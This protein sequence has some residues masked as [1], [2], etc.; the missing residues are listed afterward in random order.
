[1]NKEIKILWIDDE[2]D[3]LKPH[4][5]FLEEK[6]YKVFTAY[7]ADD[8]FEMVRDAF[9]HIILLDEHMPGING[10]EALSRL[11]EA[12]PSSPVIMITKS[13][14]EN[15]MEEA[16]GANIDDYLIKPVN[17]KQILLS[18]KKNI[19]TDK[20]VSE[21][22]I[23]NYQ[24]EFQELSGLINEAS[25]PEDW[26]DIYRKIVYWELTLEGKS[27]NGMQEVLRTQKGEANNAFSK[28]ISRYYTSWFTDNSNKPLISP[29]IFKEKVFPSIDD[30]T[31]VFFL[32]IDNLRYDHWQVLKPLITELFAVEEEELYYSIL[33]TATQYSRNS[34]FAG[35]MPL[36][37]SYIYPDIW[38]D[39]EEEGGKNLKEQSLLQHQIAR[40]GYD[41]EFSYD[42]IS[43][44]RTGKKVL[45][46]LSNLLEY[47]LSILIFNYI[48]MLS[49]SRTEMDVIKE[50]ANDES[51]YR[52]LTLSW[53]KHSPL[54]TLLKELAGK[55]V[56]I[57]LTT[58][59][60]NI[61][62]KNPV[63]VQGDKKTT[64]NLRYK[65][66]KNLSYKKNK[67]FGVSTPREIHLPKPH[68]NT[69]YIFA[70][71]QD[72]LI[73]PNNYN[74]F[75]NYYKNTF[76]HG[77]ISMEEMLIPIVTLTPKSLT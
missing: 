24:S 66:G 3:L 20:L 32:L 19:E 1:M 72:Y 37:I 13:E 40:F 76:Q 42:K 64:V 8:A 53:F 50:L 22:A 60:G 44:A 57:I 30:D 6:G 70:Y 31:N 43:H 59:H 61:Q 11:K 55:K 29:N 49:H 45:Q 62:V 33:P 46:N 17:P 47:K 58:D 26:K 28:F 38:L 36:E 10:L 52:S 39:D 4:I 56:K 2:I 77:G 51:A 69:H 71:N 7:N 14:E 15:I 12:A 73:Y 16:I 68:V 9:Y 23:S 25:H 48:D 41:F 35:L 67:V 21:K 75:A 34:L 5:L 27:E 18:I 74:Y 63:K 54:Y 65:N